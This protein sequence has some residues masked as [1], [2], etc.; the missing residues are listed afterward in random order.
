[1]FTGIIEELGAVKSIKKGQKSATLEVG[2][3]VV[4]SDVKMGDSIAVN[5]VCL[6]VVGFTGKGFS[7][8]VMAETLRKSDL[9]ALKAGDK[10]NLE[11][12]LRLSDRLGGHL[13]SG[14]IDGVG[15]IKSVVREDIALVFT[16]DAQPEVLRYIINKG[17]IAIDGISLTVVDFSEDSFRVSIIPHTAAQTTLGF[18][19]AGDNVNLESDVIAKY[20]ERMF[21][22]KG[23]GE[24]GGKKGGVDVGFL[25]EHGF[26]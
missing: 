22:G 21:P 10:V 23:G 12:A 26:L 16:V 25:A 18:K 13:V 20:V 11:R 24:D 6:T 5:G 15:T 7:A 19:K 9:G 2:A 14:H 8:E 3:T 4:A 17:S 1:M